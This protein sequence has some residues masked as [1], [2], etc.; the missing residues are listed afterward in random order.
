MQP[1]GLRDT[2]R[3]L[4]G[5]KAGVSDVEKSMMIIENN[6]NLVEEIVKEMQKLE[7]NPSSIEHFKN[8]EVYKFYYN[9]V[10]NVQRVALSLYFY[11]MLVYSDVKLPNEV[12]MAINSSQDALQWL[13]DFRLVILPYLK[14]YE[15]EFF[16]IS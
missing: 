12:R 6:L 16:P 14:I 4:P 13:D 8:S 2:T 1:S 3:L 15:K 11:R 5:L 10:E 7:F 9:Q